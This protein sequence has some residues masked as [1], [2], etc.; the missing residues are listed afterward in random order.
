M[1]LGR[2]IVLCGLLR[3]LQVGDGRCLG[4]K[5]ASVLSSPSLS[6]S[7]WAGVVGWCDGAG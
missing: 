7:L 3:L 5:V 6:P 1:W 4:F 2:A